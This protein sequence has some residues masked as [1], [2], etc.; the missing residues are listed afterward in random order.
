MRRRQTRGYDQSC[1]DGAPPPGDL[2]VRIQSREKLR[3]YHVL[4]TLLT[5]FCT[6]S[7]SPIT[8][9]QTDNM[10]VTMTS[11]TEPEAQRSEAIYLMFQGSF[12]LGLGYEPGFYQF[13]QSWSKLCSNIKTVQMYGWMASPTL[14]T[15]LWVSS[16]SWWWTGKPGVLQSMG[17]QSQDTTE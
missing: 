13:Q 11:V 17:S 6:S 7:R 8:T 5:V 15:G 9:L 14:S 2:E 1:F 3:V 12:V 4:G 10:T 16:G